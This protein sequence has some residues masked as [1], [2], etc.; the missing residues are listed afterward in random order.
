M[1]WQFWAGVL[2]G[3]L[4]VTPISLVV[5]ALLT[6]AKRADS[7]ASAPV[8]RPEHRLTDE[9]LRRIFERYDG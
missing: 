7:K 5:W 6:V 2:V 8:A 9:D 1:T 4:I 3:W